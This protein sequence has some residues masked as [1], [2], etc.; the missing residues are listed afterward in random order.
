MGLRHLLTVAAYDGGAVGT[1][2]RGRLTHPMACLRTGT[3][4]GGPS[5]CPGPRL[6]ATVRP[7]PFGQQT[8][9]RPALQWVGGPAAERAAGHGLVDWVVAGRCWGIWLG[10]WQ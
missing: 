1:R 10:S 8:V 2:S 7:G 5:P 3:F 4:S 9:W 6:A